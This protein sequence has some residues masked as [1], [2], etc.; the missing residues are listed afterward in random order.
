MLMSAPLSTRHFKLR[1]EP[2]RALQCSGVNPYC[3]AVFK[4]YG[5]PFAVGAGDPDKR[6]TH[7]TGFFADLDYWCQ[8]SVLA[9]LADEADAARRR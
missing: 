7:H 8:D 2:A 9:A 6:Y 3:R 5:H 1:D 4:K